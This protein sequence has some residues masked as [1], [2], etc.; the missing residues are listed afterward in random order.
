MKPELIEKLQ[1][2]RPQIRRRWEELLRI[3]RQ[4]TPLA[5]PDTLVFMFDR[6]LDVVMSELPRHQARTAG[7]RAIP[8]SDQNPMRIY[9]TALEQAMLEAL[10]NAQ[11]SLAKPEHGLHAAI[12]EERAA[13]ATHLC[14]TLRRIAR[15]EIE[16]LDQVCQPP[17]HKRRT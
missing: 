3:E 8:R 14:A 2:L 11:I 7:A 4:H 1:A 16:T 12:V 10:I 9:F 6:T 13:A 5:N 17:A 15:K